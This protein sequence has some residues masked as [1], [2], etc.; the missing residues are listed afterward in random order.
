MFVTGMWE[1]SLVLYVVLVTYSLDKLNYWFQKGLFVFVLIDSSLQ[2]SIHIVTSSVN[3]NDFIFFLSVCLFF[4]S[5]LFQVEHS[6]KGLVR[7]DI[8]AFFPVLR[9][10]H[11]LSIRSMLAVG[12]SCTP[13]QVKEWSF[14]FQ[15]LESFQS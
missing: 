13:I 8:L 10:K 2:F 3:K 4:F 6:L 14:C 5:L 1:N 9:G 7:E 11:S 12:F 15:F